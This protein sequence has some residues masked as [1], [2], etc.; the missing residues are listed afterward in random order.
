MKYVQALF[1]LKYEPQPRIR[2]NVNEIGDFLQSYYGTPQTVPIPDEFMAEAPRIILNSKMGH[3]QI[4]F[5]QISV[6]FK[7]NFD[8]EFVD[9]FELT[10][11]YIHKRILLL[12]ELL[13]KIGIDDYYFCGI[14][15]NVHL[16]TDAEKPVDYMKKFLGKCVPRD[17]EI[18]E[19]S[20]RVALI[21]EN[22]YFVNEQIGTYKEYQSKAG[23]IPNLI[24]FTNSRLISEGVNLV[25]DVNDRYGYLNRGTGISMACFETTIGKFFELIEERLHY[26]R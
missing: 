2:R 7:V 17:N 19:I 8:G 24:D 26:W 13:S 5:S 9:N 1:S 23:S 20:Q 3:S 25:I 16:D 10:K 15:Y 22:N 11:E 6:D 18:Y 4:S 12:K 14:S 21:K